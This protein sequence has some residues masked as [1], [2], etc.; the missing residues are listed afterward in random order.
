MNTIIALR[1]SACRYLQNKFQSKKTRRH[2]FDKIIR[3]QKKNRNYRFAIVTLLLLYCETNSVEQR[4][5]LHLALVYQMSRLN[6]E[7][8]EFINVLHQQLG[9]FFNSA[10][11]P[12]V[13]DGL[14]QVFAYKLT[15]QDQRLSTPI[16]VY[17]TYIDLC[18]HPYRFGH[19]IE[20]SRFE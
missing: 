12:L 20:S 9:E 4:T 15:P 8:G 3:E 1:Q 19:L 6:C 11:R 7:A 2:I 10:S 14:L 5:Q 16:K 18:S 17:D 13:I